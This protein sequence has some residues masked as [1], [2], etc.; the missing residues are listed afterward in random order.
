VPHSLAVGE[1]SHP[2]QRIQRRRFSSPFSEPRTGTSWIPV[3]VYLLNATISQTIEQR[4]PTRPA[5]EVSFHLT[6]WLLYLPMRNR[7][8][9]NCFV[10]GSTCG[11]LRLDSSQ[12][13][14]AEKARNT[15]KNYYLIKVN[16]H[17]LDIIDFL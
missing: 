14:C 17:Y 8:S 12:E 6:R 1:K 10:W 16:S 9:Q 13:A 7:I 5:L 11:S 3:A 2:K 15:C 4:L